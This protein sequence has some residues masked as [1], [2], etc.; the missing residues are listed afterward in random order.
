MILYSQAS[1]GYD[2][3]AFGPHYLDPQRACKPFLEK[4]IISIPSTLIASDSRCYA[5]FGF[6]GF[7]SGDRTFLSRLESRFAGF[8][9]PSAPF[10]AVFAS[11]PFSNQANPGPRVPTA[12]RIEAFSSGAAEIAAAM[13]CSR[14]AGSIAMAATAMAAAA[15]GAARTAEATIFPIR[16][17]SLAL[18]GVFCGSMSVLIA[19]AAIRG[20]SSGRAWTAEAT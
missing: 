2:K 3:N 9:M 10:A 12:A 4:A 11:L 14:A 20:A 17:V 1:G 19:V 15:D 5:P 18:S 8:N 6:F 7:F 13:I 16:S